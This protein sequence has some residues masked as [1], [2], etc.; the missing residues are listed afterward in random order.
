MASLGRKN[1][2]EGVEVPEESP[3]T[4]NDK[5]SAPMGR[6]QRDNDFWYSPNVT[7]VGRSRFIQSVYHSIAS[8]DV[9]E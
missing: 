6:N 9:Y 4:K 2:G 1:A 7:V 8:G 3:E 5:P